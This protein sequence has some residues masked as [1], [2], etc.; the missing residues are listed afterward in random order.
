MGLSQEAERLILWTILRMGLLEAP[1]EVGLLL[2][3]SLLAFHD[4]HH[5]IKLERRGVG[6]IPSENTT[7]RAVLIE[8][9]YFFLNKFSFCF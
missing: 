4:Y 5:F 8:I 7:D 9:R 2:S 6:L 3:V 1:E